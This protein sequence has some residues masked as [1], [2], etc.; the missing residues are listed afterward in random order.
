MQYHRAKGPQD[1]D[2]DHPQLCIAD[3]DNFLELMILSSRSEA[4][5]EAHRQ[6]RSFEVRGRE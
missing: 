6:L 1:W 5:G 3:S 2:T 4:F